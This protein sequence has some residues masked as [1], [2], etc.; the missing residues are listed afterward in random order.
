MKKF[1]I[2]RLISLLGALLLSSIPTF[3]NPNIVEITSKEVPTPYWSHVDKM[4]VG[5]QISDDGIATA[6]GGIVSISGDSV[7]LTVKLQ[8]FKDSKWVTLYTWEDEGIAIAAT[9]GS[10]ALAKGYSY[11]TYVTGR[12]LDANGKCLESVSVESAS[13]FYQ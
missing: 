3:A 2:I 11:R 1:K 7:D 9:D 4:S 5:L 12:V 13:Q 6:S 8:Q 10:R